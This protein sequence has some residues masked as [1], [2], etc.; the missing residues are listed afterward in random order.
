[1]ADIVLREWDLAPYPGDQAPA[2]IHH[3]SDEA[4]VVLAGEL[5]MLIGDQRSVLTAGEYAV[6]PAGTV[7]TF[8]THGESGS[9][10]IAVLTP[11]IDELIRALHD[12]A[13]GDS[14]AIWARYN[15][16]VA[17]PPAS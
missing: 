9:R 15:A 7:H 10:I 17:E 6:I 2:H 11:E 3:G 5:E 1:V 14:Q 12:D 13:G 16:S 8:A 4:F